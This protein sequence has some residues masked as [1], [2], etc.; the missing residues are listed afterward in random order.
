[1]S[2]VRHWALG[3]VFVLGLVGKIAAQDR[4]VVV[5]MLGGGYS[6]VNNLNAAGTAH[7]NTGFNAGIAVGYQA[8]QYV[9]IHGDLALARNKAIG[10]MPFANTSFNRYFYGAHIELSYPVT[11]RFSPF[12]FGGGGGVTIDQQGTSG[13]ATF[14]KPAAMFGAGMSFALPNSNASVLLEGKGL[15]YKWDKAGFNKTQF[16][17]SYS[18]GFAYRFRS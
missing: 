14:T 2:R 4:G 15:T 13:I 17:L 9:G 18:L 16:D 12:V 7:W 10:V 6:H 8:N 1:M 11:E 3:G 5:Q